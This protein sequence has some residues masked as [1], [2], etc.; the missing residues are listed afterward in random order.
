MSLE[1]KTKLSPGRNCYGHLSLSEGNSYCFSKDN[2]EA[3]NAFDNNANRRRQSVQTWSMVGML[4]GIAGSL[5]AQNLTG[6][7]RLQVAAV[8]VAVFATTMLGTLILGLSLNTEKK[9]ALQRYSS[10]Q[11]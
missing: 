5:W 10:P 7:R 2:W 9:R 1:V 8:T 11:Q 4:V 3:W 6:V